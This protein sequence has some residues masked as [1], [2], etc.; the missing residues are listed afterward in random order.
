MYEYLSKNHLARL[1]RN[2]DSQTA[3]NG[4]IFFLQ[5]P[6]TEATLKC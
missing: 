1:K 3:W 2:F 6:P 5:V 4:V